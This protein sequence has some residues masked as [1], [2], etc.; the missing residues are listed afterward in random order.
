M[1]A[2]L[3]RILETGETVVD[4]V[5]GTDAAAALGL[6]PRQIEILRLLA[7]GRSNRAIAEALSITEGTVK[8]HVSTIIRSLGVRNR[9]E[10]AACYSNFR[11]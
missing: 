9:T 6:T 5:S 8:I 10:A 7:N 1:L 4:G 3:R 11:S 2:Y